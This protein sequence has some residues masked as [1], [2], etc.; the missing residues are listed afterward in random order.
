MNVAIFV[1]Y[2]C[3]LKTQIFYD[4]RFLMLFSLPGASFG[5]KTAIFVQHK[6][7]TKECNNSHSFPCSKSSQI[8][9]LLTQNKEKPFSCS[10][11]NYSCSL[12]WFLTRHIRTHTKEKPFFAH[13]VTVHSHGSQI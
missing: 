10:Y 13:S 6:R 4:F 7:D 9:H 2:G 11:C 8:A 12:K 5:V 3:A 1:V